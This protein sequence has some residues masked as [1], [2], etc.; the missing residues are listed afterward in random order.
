[1]TIINYPTEKILSACD[2]AI[3]SQ[4]DRIVFY[5]M[6]PQHERLEGQ[7]NQR[8]HEESLQSHIDKRKEFYL[9]QSRVS[10][11]HSL[12]EEDFNLIKRYL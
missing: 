9:I 10:Q 3:E 6:I 7:K 4:N 5:E 11:G 2:R 1:M 8:T 12:T